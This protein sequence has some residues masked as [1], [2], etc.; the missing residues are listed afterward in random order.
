RGAWRHLPMRPSLLKNKGDGTF[1]DV[2]E[3][4]GLIAAVNSNSACWADYDNDG[5][6]DLFVCCEQQPNRLYRNRG[7]GT[8]EEAAQKHGLGDSGQFC[9]GAAWIHFDTDC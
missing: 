4:A 5:H 2:T 7:D 1:I 8:F 6:L 9:K 3:K